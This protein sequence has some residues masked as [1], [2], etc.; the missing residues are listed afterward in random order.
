[1]RKTST[2]SEC[3]RDE[4]FRFLW[5][6]TILYIV[7]VTFVFPYL[8][9]MNIQQKNKTYVPL[10]N[11][12]R[13]LRLDIK[14]GRV[15]KNRDGAYVYTQKGLES[16]HKDEVKERLISADRFRNKLLR[17]AKKRDM[18]RKEAKRLE[19]MQL[20]KELEEERQRE[21]DEER[22][23]YYKMESNLAEIEMRLFG[24]NRIDDG[25]FLDRTSVVFS[26]LIRKPD[27]LS[28]FSVKN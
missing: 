14:E 17:D 24:R 25:M 19:Q 16:I 12:R 2:T 23:W 6:Y 18:R 21:E 20:Q 1:M 9:I 15:T 8:C 13:S 11:R 7:V 10:Q 5:Y 22:R 28:K 4:P 3:T 27:L 26:Q